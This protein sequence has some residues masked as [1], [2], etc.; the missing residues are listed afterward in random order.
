MCGVS[1]GFLELFNQVRRTERWPDNGN[2]RR[3]GEAWRRI[4]RLLSLRRPIDSQTP[5]DFDAAR[6]N[7]NELRARADR[8]DF[9]LLDNDV[10]LDDIRKAY[11]R[12][13]RLTNETSTQT[14][15]RQCFDAILGGI[16]AKR[17]KQITEAVINAYRESRLVEVS[18]RTV[19]MEVEGLS[20]MLDW[21]VATKHI[22]S[23]PLARFRSLPTKGKEV[24]QRRALT[25]EEVL[26]ILDET[27]NYIKP[28]F[29]LFLTAGVRSGEARNL[30]FSDVDFD[31][32]TITIR[33]GKGRKSK[34]AREIPLDEDVLAM[35]AQLHADAPS[36]VPRKGY[37]NAIDQRIDATFSKEHV[38]VTGSGTPWDGGRLLRRFYTV[39]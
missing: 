16:T 31:R 14:R 23:N 35:I 24:K 25:V 30:L 8:A 13:C 5:S 9:G 39:C 38:F 27:P 22:G 18:Q 6:Q 12:H 21:A 29:R 11:E 26:T 4:P 36:R 1:R 20:T 19:N 17:V 28:V 2:C 37:G 3:H 32:A 33:A 7:L 15:K 10:P 34:K